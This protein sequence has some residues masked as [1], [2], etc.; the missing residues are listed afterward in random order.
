MGVATV[1]A[2]NRVRTAAEAWGSPSLPPRLWSAVIDGWNA[3]RPEERRARAAECREKGHEW[4]GTPLGV[5][6]CLR[7]CRYDG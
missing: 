7:C 2:E 6:M 3:R 4:R 1:A 5:D